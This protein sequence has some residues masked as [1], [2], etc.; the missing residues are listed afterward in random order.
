VLELYYGKPST[1]E[2][3]SVPVDPLHIREM[4]PAERGVL[5]ARVLDDHP[6]LIELVPEHFRPLEG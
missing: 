2:S 4:T 6:R 3:E 5:L 1:G